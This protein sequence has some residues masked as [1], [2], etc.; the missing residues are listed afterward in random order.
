MWRSFEGMKPKLPS[1]PP[2]DN[3]FVKNG[4]NPMKVYIDNISITRQKLYS[5]SEVVDEVE[6][7]IEVQYT[8]V[9]GSNELKG[10]C[11]FLIE[12]KELTIQQI[13]DRIANGTRA[14]VNE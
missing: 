11:E 10:K 13:E 9:S 4:G 14:M 3:K 12:C 7:E 8:I 1:K 2:K 6:S 5:N